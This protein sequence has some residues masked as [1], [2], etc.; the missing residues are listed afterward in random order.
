[1]PPEIEV[2]EIGDGYL[3]ARGTGPDDEPQVRRYRVRK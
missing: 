2:L 1:M 3:L